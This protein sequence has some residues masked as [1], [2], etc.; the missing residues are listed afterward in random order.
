MRKART[1]KTAAAE[2]RASA[3]AAGMHPASHAAAMHATAHTATMAAA[4][5]TTASERRWRKGKRRSE[6]TRDEA[7]KDLVIHPNSSVV[8]SQRRIPSQEEDDQQSQMIQ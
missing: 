4:T 8:E 7:T 5:A 6:R 3:H 1:R 2:M